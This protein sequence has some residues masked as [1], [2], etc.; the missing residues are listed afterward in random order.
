MRECVLLCL[1]L[2]S[3]LVNVKNNTTHVEAV[4]KYVKETVKYE[5]GSFGR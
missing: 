5:S 3:L 4:V 2:F 1:G